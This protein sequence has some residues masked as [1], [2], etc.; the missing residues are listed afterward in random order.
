MTGAAAWLSAGGTAAS[1]VAAVVAAA[2]AV[3]QVPKW[4]RSRQQEAQALEDIARSAAEVPVIVG[5]AEDGSGYWAQFGDAVPERFTGLEDINDQ[6]RKLGLRE[7]TQP[8]GAYI[9]DWNGG[10]GDHGAQRLCL[11]FASRTVVTSQPGKWVVQLPCAEHEEYFRRPAVRGG[12]PVFTIPAPVDR[13]GHGPV[14]HKDGRT[15]ISAEDEQR[16]LDRLLNGHVV[17]AEVFPGA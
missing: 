10:I 8:A 3:V 12:W 16:A 15:G 17:P 5:P 4:R 9:C 7:R 13:H 11:L 14:F 6:I 1:G 2:V